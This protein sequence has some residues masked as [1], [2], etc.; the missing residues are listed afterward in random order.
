M[1]IYIYIFIHGPFSSYVRLPE[2]SWIQEQFIHSTSQRHRMH[3]QELKGHQSWS[4][5][6]NSCSKIYANQN[7]NILSYPASWTSDPGYISE[8]AFMTN[9][10]TTVV[11]YFAN[12]FLRRVS[13]LSIAK[14]HLWRARG[15]Q[16]SEAHLP[17]HPF[18][19]GKGS[20]DQVLLRRWD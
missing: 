6:Y 3:V 7:I 1:Y 20:T 15:K 16:M 8:S 4:P 9:K 11:R 5:H 2:C 13:N 18:P 19:Q 10:P 17:M 14:L 12:P